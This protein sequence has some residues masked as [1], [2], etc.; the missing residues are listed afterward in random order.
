M[1]GING[2][3]MVVAMEITTTVPILLMVDTVV[4]MVVMVVV[5]GVMDHKEVVAEDLDIILIMV[6]IGEYSYLSPVVVNL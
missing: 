4:A 2:V 6:K 5:M 1:D 3:V